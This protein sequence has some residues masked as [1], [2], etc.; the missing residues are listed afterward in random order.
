MGLLSRRK[1]QSAAR[2]KLARD[3]RIV[4]WASTSDGPGRAV[5][6]TTLGVWIPGRDRLGW[7]Q[8]HKAIW[9]PPRL[10]IIGAAL[11]EARPTYDVMADDAP[12]GVQ[13][14]DADGVPEEIRKRVTRSVAQTLH[15]RLPGGGVRVVAR[16]V[17]GVDGVRWH[18]RYDAGTDR[19]A[20]DVVAATD[21]IVAALA[22]PSDR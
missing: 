17:P 10:T 1:L 9:S 13:L 18:V 4:A 7:H 15:D 22:T 3:E 8:I 21:E 19:T 12:V 5:V 20:P 6:V 2:P 16:R 11:I 14:A